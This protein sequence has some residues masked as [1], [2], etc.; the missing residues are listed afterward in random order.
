MK[1]AV[2]ILRGGPSSEHAHSL[3]T[4]ATFLASL[5]NERYQG[6]DI[7]IDRNGVWHRGGVPQSPRQALT[8]AEVVLNGLHGYYGEDGKVQILLNQLGIPHSSSSPVASALGMHKGHTRDILMKEGIKV[9][10]GV[11]LSI[12]DIVQEKVRDVFRAL[13]GPYVVKPV[14]AGSAQGLSMART[15]GELIQAVAEA[16]EHSPQVLIERFIGGKEVVAGVIEGYRGEERYGLIPIGIG[17]GTGQVRGFKGHGVTPEM[18]KR[19]S[20]T[21]ERVHHMLG[22]RHYSAIDC[23]VTPTDIYVLEINTQPKLHEDSPFV[24]SLKE[25]GSDVKHFVRHLV[26]KIR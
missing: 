12:D 14:G 8:G 3:K 18:S 15:Y 26:E 24:H 6:I 25:V 10:E 22:A 20:R 5:D 2:A 13:P 23:I 4:G 16:F 19:I 11:L 21:A 7:Y 9:P 17:L 1:T